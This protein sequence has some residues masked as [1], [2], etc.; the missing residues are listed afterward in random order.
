MSFPAPLLPSSL[1]CSELNSIMA[2]FRIAN[3]ADTKPSNAS[4]YAAESLSLQH[5][6]TLSSRRMALI[7]L[8]A[9]TAAAFLW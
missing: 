9:W 7:T 2:A 1:V 3:T 4:S 8:Y 5:L 6:L